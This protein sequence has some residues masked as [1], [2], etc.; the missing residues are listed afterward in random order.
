MIISTQKVNKEYLLHA[1]KGKEVTQD[2]I[3]E[4]FENEEQIETF[5]KE[6]V[7]R[8]GFSRFQVLEMKD[9]THYYKL[10]K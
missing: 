2:A 8:K 7:Q 10:I 9:G 4:A 3:T 6:Y 5:F 1:L